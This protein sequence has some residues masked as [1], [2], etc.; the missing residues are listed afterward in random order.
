M[1]SRPLATA[2][3]DPPAK[4][5]DPLSDDSAAITDGYPPENYGAEVPQT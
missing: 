4:P 5:P 1:S 3:E 2:M